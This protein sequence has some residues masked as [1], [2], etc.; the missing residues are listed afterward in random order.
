MADFDD[1]AVMMTCNLPT[2]QQI[3]RAA[4]II[5]V[6]RGAFIGDWPKFYDDAWNILLVSMNQTKIMI[7]R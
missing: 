3:E 6:A 4:K 5:A 2:E 7:G 1:D